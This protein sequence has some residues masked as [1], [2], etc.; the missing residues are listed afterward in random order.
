MGVWKAESASTHPASNV[1]KKADA[2]A[3]PLTFVVERQLHGVN[4][5]TRLLPL[6]IMQMPATA[7]LQFHYSGHNE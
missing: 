6:V 5:A 3:P 7:Y 2:A 1:T 4:V